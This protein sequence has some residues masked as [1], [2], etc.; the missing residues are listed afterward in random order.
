[1]AQF[2]TRIKQDT[3]LKFSP[4]SNE[5]LEVNIHNISAVYMGEGE[6]KRVVR[7]YSTE[8]CRG[9]FLCPLCPMHDPLINMVDKRMRYDQNGRE[10]HFP[11]ARKF[12][13]LGWDHNDNEPRILVASKTAVRGMQALMEEHEDITNYT[14]KIK[15]EK[16]AYV[17]TSLA[18]AEKEIHLDGVDVNQLLD[19]MRQRFDVDYRTPRSS[20]ELAMAIDPT[21]TKQDRGGMT[22][23]PP[24]ESEPVAAKPPVKKAKASEAPS[25]PEPTT[26]ASADFDVDATKREII[27]LA[28]QNGDK[29]SEINEALQEIGLDGLNDIPDASALQALEAIRS[30]VS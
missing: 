7:R 4:L 22:P 11:K 23:P 1:M 30:V 18:R 5:I 24:R 17:S 19:A 13:V 3:P 2:Y 16:P 27:M 6:N 20:E 12:A 10:Q 15:F 25:E 9:G 26:E 14:F 29:F 8:P 28:T 21:T